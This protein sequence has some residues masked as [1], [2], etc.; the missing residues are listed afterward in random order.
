ML[1]ARLEIHAERALSE[2]QFDFRRGRSTDDA[3]SRVIMT[4][5]AVQNRE[6]CVMITLDVKNTFNSAPWHLIER[7]LSRT[8]V[9]LYLV[10][11]MRSYMH[12][13]SLQTTQQDGREGL[14]VTCGV[15]Q[16]SVLGPTL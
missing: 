12:N 10:K 14:P 3:I 8:N 7:A 4:A 2:N 16:G 13:R 9:S 5:E 15:P 11:I 1:L 6:L